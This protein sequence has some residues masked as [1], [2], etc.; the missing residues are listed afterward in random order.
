[1]RVR[2]SSALSRERAGSGHVQRCTVVARALHVRRSCL[3][4]PRLAARRTAAFRQASRRRRTERWRPTDVCTG[5]RARRSAWEHVAVTD[6]TS[7]KPGNYLL[8]NR[9]SEAGQRFYS[10]AALVQPRDLPSRREARNHRWLACWEV[11]AGGPSVP[12]WLSS[13]V[14]PSGKVLATDIDISW[15]AGAAGENIEV[16]QHNVA[17]DDPPNA[18][19]D[20]VHARLVLIHVPEQERALQHIVRAVR[21]GG[22]LLIEDF[23]PAMQPLACVDVVGPEERLANKIPRGLPGVAR[24]SEER[25]WSSV[26]GCRGCCGRRDWLTSRR[27]RSCLWRWPQVPGW[28][29]PISARYMKGSS[30]AITRPQRRSRHTR[31]PWSLDAST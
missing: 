13:Q 26:V 17:T 29:R 1:M 4:M 23:D 30:K 25:T 16:L 3:H 18:T 10:L 24:G 19:F 2:S 27:A 31:S 21:P 5:R 14:G 20:L 12:E 7:P 8:D 22:W 28:R 6:V 9:A 11:G 15:T